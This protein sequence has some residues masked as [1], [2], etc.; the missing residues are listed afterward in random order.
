MNR[1][2]KR[3]KITMPTYNVSKTFGRQGQISERSTSVMRMFGLTADRLT[4]TSFTV[5][6]QVQINDGDIVYIT[7]PSG[8]GKSVLLKELEKSVPASDK[9]NLNEVKLPCD[10]SV[11]DC[12]DGST[13]SPYNGDFLQGLKLLSIAGLNDAFC[14]LNQPANLS[15][16]QKYRF[17]LA[18][19][20]GSGAKFIFA[21]EFCSGLDRITAAV[22]SYNI[23]KYAKRTGVIFILASSH[24]DI[25]LDLAPDVLVVQELSGPTQVIYKRGKI[26]RCEAAV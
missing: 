1:E 19:A 5:N 8:A 14:V 18:A 2:Q 20:L 15:D 22:I 13:G 12:I 4:E 17:R 11:I 21:D 6:C 23:Q 24:E 7:G 9:M 3:G 26:Q 25:L 16:G 10:K